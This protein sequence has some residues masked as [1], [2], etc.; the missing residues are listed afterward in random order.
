MNLLQDLRY[1][2]RLLR[3][4]PGFAV[5]AILSLALGIGANSAIFQLLDAI[6]LRMLPIK[7]PQS[8]VQAR[9]VNTKG[10][11]GNQERDLDGVTNPI[12]EQIRSRQQVFSGIFAWGTETFNIS[13]QGEMRPARGLWVSGDFFPVLRVPAVLGRVFT[14]ADD[15]RGC[16]L[17]GAVIS[18]SF[19][20]REFGGE[21]SAIGR[22]VVVNSHPVDV[23]GV[24][25]ESFFGLEVGRSFD[26]ALPICSDA[27]LRGGSGR[28]DSGTNWWLV[29]MGR[30]RPGMPVERVA[31]SLGALSAGVFEASLSAGYPPVSVKDFLA[32][33]LTAIPAGTGLS[34]LRQRYSD[35]LALL[36][37]IAGLVL[38]I[39]CANL[40]N[41]MLA[42]ASARGREIA[43]RLAI[44]ASRSQLI[45][46]LMTE[47]LLIAAAGAS[48]GLL[49]SR[50]LSRFLV[51]FLNTQGNAVF[52]DLQQD[53]RVLAFTAGL[54][55]LTSVLFGLTPAWRAA[56]TAPGEVLKSGSRGMTA[57]RERFS[58]RRI[59]VSSQIAI[60][61]VLL[62]G[63]LLFVESLRT[64]MT[65]ETGF[66]QDGLL[67]ASVGFSRVDL[68]QDRLPGFRR[69]MLDRL[70]AIPG[71]N[72]VTET[73]QVPVGG[74]Q[75]SNALW[76]DGHSREGADNVHRSFIGAAYFKTLGTPLLAGREF[77]DRDT[78]TSTK[79]VVVNEAFARKFTSG[80]NPVG[81][82][83]W[84][85]ATPSSPQEVCE[86]VGLVRN[87]KYGDLRE[88]FKPI[89][90]SSLNQTPKPITD[91]RIMIR[92]TASLEPLV[93]AVRA[94]L[95]E[96]NP[97][98]RYAF[99][100]FPTV[101]RDSLLRERLMAT[102]S[103]FFGGLAVLLATIGLYGVIAYM[104]AQRTNEIGIRMALGAGRGDVLRL[105][106]RE[107]GMLLAG[108]LVLGTMLA[109]LAARAI[110]SLLFGVHSNDPMTLVAAASA[111]AAVALAAS[112]LPARRAA[113]LD[114]TVAL[115]QD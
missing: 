64:L 29:V 96:M 43:I 31:A 38:L 32:M 45:R 13:P 92:S 10:M 47:S 95:R 37:G 50:A 111:L 63:S 7:D 40:A 17:P 113:R 20:Q 109:L 93:E 84:I 82:R 11:R 60:S 35:P 77:D 22:K 18:Y 1:A 5:V 24:T 61:L 79:V 102:L 74:G 80:A 115:R 55:I 33:K 8:L 6:R 54:A 98:I 86:I 46:Q 4:N 78:S 85:E 34:P 114:P 48:F 36:L 19:W 65:L 89:A 75:T 87:T 39:A 104:V 66:R 3:L 2:A 69:E 99:R 90:F 83:L 14:A 27:A 94:T 16:G 110:E 30:P 59:L 71:V 9:L 100:T 62:A 51:S 44:G 91:S 21:A 15:R 72:G 41:L 23:I 112:Y 56:Q 12:W 68:P 26:I 57:G 106:L 81:K 101:I 97:D 58:L 70:R 88:D 103:G 42:R 108:G 53:W 73:D 28:L 49:L 67:I 107:A 105:I 25:S 76:M 52:V